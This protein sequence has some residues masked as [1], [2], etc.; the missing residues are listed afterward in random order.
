MKKRANT[1]SLIW[2]RKQRDGLIGAIKEDI[3]LLKRKIYDIDDEI[4]DE[5]D[6][7][8]LL[9]NEIEDIYYHTKELVALNDEIYDIE[10][11]SD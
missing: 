1:S 7:I 5:T 3:K 2:L 6:E 10:Y 8:R 9:K 11:E 4:Y